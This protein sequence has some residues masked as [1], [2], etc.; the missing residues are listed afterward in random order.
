M[1]YRAHDKFIMHT[2][3]AVNDDNHI[4]NFLC[5]F[6]PFSRV[7]KSSP[8]RFLLFSS[9]MF[10]LQVKFMSNDFLLSAPFSGRRRLYSLANE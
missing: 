9:L 6:L 4:Y 5:I 7:H 1:I 3:H 8:N 2:H 10:P